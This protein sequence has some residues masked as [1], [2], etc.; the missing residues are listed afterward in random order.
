M[1]TDSWRVWGIGND[2]RGIWP[3]Q[4]PPR[5]LFAMYYTPAPSSAS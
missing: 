2:P 3:C 1:T 4:R 5:P